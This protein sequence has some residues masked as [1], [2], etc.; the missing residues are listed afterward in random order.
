MITVRAS[1]R[2]AGRDVP[3]RVGDEDG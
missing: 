1:T 2:I 3:A